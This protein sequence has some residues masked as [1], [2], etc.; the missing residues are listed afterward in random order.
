ME[1]YLLRHGIAALRRPRRHRPDSNRPLTA[2][3]ARRIRRIA[4]A[5]KDLEMSFDHIISSPYMRA[6]GT[7]EIIAGVL[8]AQDTLRFS[9]E[10]TPTGK[11]RSLIREI[12]GLHPAPK[13]LL[14]VGHEP[15]LSGL[16]SLLVT[17]HP[18]FSLTLKKGG[19]CKLSAESLEYSR[20][21]TLEWLLTPRHLMAMG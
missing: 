14:L 5:M 9:E 16:I 12:N 19:L 3:G 20:C 6:K 7:A 17:G 8:E 2:K 15:F 10:L 1:L 21:A 18:G 13:S 11:P 4:E